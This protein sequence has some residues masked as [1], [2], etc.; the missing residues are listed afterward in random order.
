M[1]KIKLLCY[2][3]GIS[4]ASQASAISCR[5]DVASVCG[6]SGC[7]RAPSSIQSIVIDEAN[8]V[9]TRC[10]KT[11]CD[12]IPVNAEASGAMLKFGAIGNGYLIVV[13]ILDLSFSEVATQ[14]SAVYVKSGKCRR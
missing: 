1:K 9:V 8:S 10:D 7:E 2:I 11:G 14:L 4:F 5:P 12:Q 13:N 6:A 3:L